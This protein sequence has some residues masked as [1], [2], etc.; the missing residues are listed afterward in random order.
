MLK[1]ALDNCLSNNLFEAKKI[2]SEILKKFPK[3][4]EA[5]SNLGSIELQLGNVASGIE[6]LKKSTKIDESQ[7]NAQFNLANGLIKIGEYD[8]ALQVLNICIKYNPNNAEAYNNRGTIFNHFGRFD[9]ALDN[10]NSAIRLKPD[11]MEAY[12]NR[13]AIFNH[14]GRFDQALDDFNSAIRLKPDYADNF[15]QLGLTL[16]RLGKYDDAILNYKKAIILNPNLFEAQNNLGLIYLHTK[17]FKEGWP[18]YEKRHL[19]IQSNHEK[20]FS[21]LLVNFSQLN[22]SKLLITGEQG[23]GDNIIY[24]SLFSNLTNNRNKYIVAF[25]KRLINIYQ[26]S[27]PDIQFVSLEEK[28][29]VLHDFYLPIGNLGNIFISSTLDFKRQ[30]IKFLQDDKSLTKQ[31]KSKLNL[32]KQYICG[33]SWKSKNEALSGSKNIPLDKLASILQIKNI[34]FID[35]QYGETMDDKN[36]IEDK[37]GIKIKSIT[38]LDKFND[39][40]GLASM[41]SACDFVITISNITAHLAGALGIKT[42]LLLPYSFGKIWYWHEGEGKSLWYPSIEM[43]SQSVAGDWESPVN[44]ISE[45]LK[46]YD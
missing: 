31:F 43:Y 12:S 5:L 28:D 37:Y 3:Q 20:Y 13:G 30:P 22:Q 7:S 41:I 16:Y 26:R 4:P 29:G 23:I 27:F 15:N 32:K 8:E 10:Y 38:E 36:K 1:R 19:A 39:I 46:K 44:A 40:D 6:L 11:Y 2:Y 42:Y 18:L 34:T 9:E 17:N 24:S 14:F 45:K 25:D 35:L 33:I 21:K